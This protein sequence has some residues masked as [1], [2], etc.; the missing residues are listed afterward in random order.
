MIRLTNQ[1]ALFASLVGGQVAKSIPRFSAVQNEIAKHV[2]PPIP[3]LPLNKED[4]L[5]LEDAEVRDNNWMADRP[6]IERQFFPLTFRRRLPKEP[7]YTLPYEPM[8]TISGKNNIVKRTVAKNNEFV[9]TIKERFSQDDYD[10]T[11]TGALFGKQMLGGHAECFPR[12][13][14]EKLRDYCTAPEGLEVKCEVLQLLGINHIVVE[15]FTFP[16]TKGENVQAY[17][18]KCLSDFTSEFLLEIKE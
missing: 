18:I 11:I 5:T 6:N 10:I 17:E 8:I 13:D 7:F 9:G 2:L 16:F 12:V 14:F 15:S 3:F 1:Q 4:K